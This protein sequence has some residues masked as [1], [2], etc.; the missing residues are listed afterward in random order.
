LGRADAGRGAYGWRWAC[1][2]RRY[3][4][5][6]GC[7]LRVTA[8]QGRDSLLGGGIGRH[9]HFNRCHLGRGRWT[10]CN[11]WWL[12][13]W[14]DR[15]RL[16]WGWLW[17]GWRW[18]WRWKWRRGWFNFGQ[19]WRGFLQQDGLY[20]L[21]QLAAD[22]ARQASLNGPKNHDV[23]HND[24]AQTPSLAPGAGLQIGGARHRCSDRCW[25]REA[26]YFAG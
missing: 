5:Y 13:C 16:R 12:R 1:W 20:H 21:G 14:R 18:Q 11:D 2:G 8:G 23:Q 15:R 10:G 7:G 4:R 6:G 9:R 3:S 25:N 26:V 24:H 22:V 19:R 17:C